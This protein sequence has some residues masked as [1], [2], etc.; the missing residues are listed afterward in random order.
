MNPPKL[1]VSL[2]AAMITLAGTRAYAH[3]SGGVLLDQQIVVIIGE[4]SLV[5]EYT[6]LHNRPF[7]GLIEIPRADVDGDSAVTRDELQTY[8]A[9]LRESIRRGLELTIDGREA[10][11]ELTAEEMSM[12][13]GPDEVLGTNDD[14]F[15][16][17]YRL[18]TPHPKGWKKGTLVELH[19]ENFLN[20]AGTTTIDLEPGSA[21]DVVYDSLWTANEEDENAEYAGPRAS[22]SRQQRDIVFRYRGGTGVYD[23]Q[24]ESVASTTGADAAGG[25]RSHDRIGVAPPEGLGATTVFGV[26]LVIG[27]IGVFVL[28]R[29]VRHIPRASRIALGAASVVLI[30]GGAVLIVCDAFVGPWQQTAAVP[31]DVEAKQIFQRLH[32]GI[33]DAFAARTEDEIYDTLAGSLRGQPLGDVYNE[34]YEALRMRTQGTTRF[35]VRRIKPISTR[36]LPAP[37]THAPAFCVRYRWRVYGTVTHYRHTHARLNEYEAVYVVSHDG[38]GWRISDTQVRR[39]QRVSVDQT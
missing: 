5:I 1:V 37:R 38:R 13:P 29:R 32:L 27:S 7:A 26:I 23:P 18:L 21:A 22:L 9:G 16:R 14:R 12:D 15:R 19:N 17:D 3:S 31:S 20:V 30:A 34:V 33:Y 11:L 24:R 36:V 4:D 25:D 8:W 10:P 6:T 39:H 2:V 35:D 28:V